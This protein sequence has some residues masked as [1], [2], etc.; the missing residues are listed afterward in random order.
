LGA[1]RQECEVKELFKNAKKII[2]FQK[3]RVYLSL[4]GV[5]DVEKENISCEFEEEG[6]DLKIK[7][8]KNQNL[9]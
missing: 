9:R 1:R 8:F 5:G 2:I 4:D 7:G 6:F 3:K